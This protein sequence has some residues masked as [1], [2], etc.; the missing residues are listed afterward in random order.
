M[1]K[2]ILFLFFIVLNIGI[3]HA[4]RLSPSAIRIYYMPNYEETFT[5]YTDPHASSQVI[6]EGDLAEYVSVV[7]NNIAR[8][9]TFRVKVKL[10]Q[11]IEIPGQHVVYVQVMDSPTEGGNINGI[12]SVRTGIDIRVPYPGYFAEFNF[13]TPHLNVGQ[14]AVMGI[15]VANKGTLNFT[16]QATV[17]IFDKNGIRQGTLTVPPKFV[18]SGSEQ[19]LQAVFNASTY[20][21]GDY[22]AIATV[23]YGDKS[24]Q[25][26]STFRI[27]G[28]Q[29][30][31][32]NYSRVLKPYAINQF[33]LE[34]VSG[35]NEDIK[36]VYAQV[37]VFNETKIIGNFK[38]PF[39]DV[40]PWGSAFLTGFWDATSV[41]EG[42]YPVEMRVSYHDKFDVHKGIVELR[43]DVIVEKTET[44]PFYK[45]IN[46][47]HILIAA[48]AILVIVNVILILRKKKK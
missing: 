35:W 43:E 14:S 9:G 42:S 7:E 47:T 21:A 24:Q 16:A 28:L 23:S 26:T 25:L 3:V 41:G 32:K 8:D 4:A 22:K 30:S 17:E 37:T 48:I 5:F 15:I 34:V 1:N 6:L 45:R 46:I 44:P 36:N 2:A 27:G 13:Q 11:K 12:A 29:L 20:Q 33:S 18:I 39:A 38:T 31:L 10:P 40:L 19:T